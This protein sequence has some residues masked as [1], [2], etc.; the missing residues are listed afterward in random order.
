MRL[1]IN[2]KTPQAS[3]I[4]GF[5]D[6]VKTRV[7]QG[8]FG[9]SYGV[10]F[11]SVES[12]NDPATAK[13][14]E[15]TLAT[16]TQAVSSLLDGNQVFDVS[17]E[18]AQTGMFV[19]SSTGSNWIQ[20]H[21]MNVAK[22]AAG[23]AVQIAGCNPEDLHQASMESYKYA[24]NPASLNGTRIDYHADYTNGDR[25]SALGIGTTYAP[26]N[27]APQ[28]VKSL[29]A[30]DSSALANAMSLSITYN[31]LAAVQDPMIE[32][33]FKT[34]VM[35]HDQPAFFYEVA[36]DRYWDGYIHRPENTHAR[37][38]GFANK[39]TTM[40]AIRKPSLLKRDVLSIVPFFN[41]A[42]SA[43]NTDLFMSA[44]LMPKPEIRVVAGHSIP[45]KPLKVGVKYDLLDIS[46]HPGLLNNNSPDETD[47]LDSYVAVSDFYLSLKKGT[48]NPDEVIRLPL[49]GLERRNFVKSIQGHGEEMSLDFVST[50]FTLTPNTVS[51]AGKTPALLKPILDAGYQVRVRLE[52]NGSA[53][54]E[55]GHYHIRVVEATFESA[56]KVDKPT[57]PGQK[58]VVTKVELKDPA[59]KAELDKLSLVVEYFYPETNRTNSNLRLMGILLDRDVY[60]AKFAIGIRTP[61]RYQ[62]P[63]GRT[64]SD[65]EIV[66]ALVRFTKIRQTA[67][68]FYELFRYRDT[69]KQYTANDMSG[70]ERIPDFLGVGKFLIRPYYRH[71]GL[72]MEKLVKTTESKNA[73][74]NAREALVAVLQEAATDMLVKTEWGIAAAQQNDGNA[75]KPHFGIGCG[76]YVPLLLNIKGD[77]RLLG[78]NYDHTVASSWVED[79][80]DKI[81]M[82]FVDPK[83][84]GLQPLGFG[85]TFYYAESV[86]SVSP[87]ALNG[88]LRQTFVVQPRYQ[89]VAHLPA[90]V[91]VDIR[92]L[93]EF[94]N[95]YNL[96]QIIMKGNVSLAGG[97]A[98]AGGTSPATGT[99]APG[100]GVGP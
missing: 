24:A 55:T 58:P 19:H 45:T 66:K 85:N 79:M 39:M 30:F 74:E 33:F 56:V 87:H 62:R 23:Y 91:E 21:Q 44:S 68:G 49:A 9:Q 8:N 93:K 5:M 95:Q 22:E 16:N 89:Q 71:I 14:Y 31:L 11:V 70:E 92:G 80:D 86:V 4:A 3:A 52:A 77:L 99:G 42:G 64:E 97:A 73:L 29:E 32:M 41:D 100:A 18:S 60:T 34:V 57:A 38:E 76:Q 81:I 15:S 47:R 25:A 40:R 1:L 36:I 48:T 51:L 46:Q 63:V 98:A 13:S 6:S 54:V 83:S 90:M 50:E 43:P 78:D 28:D 94:V 67:D 61:V 84:E 65:D 96:V 35:Q 20:R 75:V 88:A 26:L 7:Q 17:N 27:L 12:W 82:S 10:E 37:R 72:E 59:L 2:S 53:N 69:L